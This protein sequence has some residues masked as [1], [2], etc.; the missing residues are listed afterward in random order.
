MDKLTKILWILT[1]T[2]VAMIVVFLIIKSLYPYSV[3]I[4][5]TAQQIITR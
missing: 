2:L 3:T 5:E 1:G 4:T